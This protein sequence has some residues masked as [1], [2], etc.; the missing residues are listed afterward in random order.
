MSLIKSLI[1]LSKQLKTDENSSTH[2]L[3][4]E[5]WNL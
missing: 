3:I 5:L 1:K 2:G 4:L